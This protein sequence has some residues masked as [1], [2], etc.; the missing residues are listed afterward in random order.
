LETE[1]LRK[2]V[3]D[4]WDEEVMDGGGV[5]HPMFLEKENRGDL[6]N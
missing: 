4:W 1:V 6:Q 5:L 2:A 3:S